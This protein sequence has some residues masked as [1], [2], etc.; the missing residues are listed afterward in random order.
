[1]HS[2]EGRDT[3][4]TVGWTMFY[5]LQ[6]ECKLLLLQQNMHE[7]IHFKRNLTFPRNYALINQ[8]RPFL[9]CVG[10]AISNF[11]VINESWHLLFMVPQ[12]HDS[13]N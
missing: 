8:E 5:S 7:S 4:I 10:D 11:G 12:Q 3:N 9:Y 6:K 2:L 1:M 13:S